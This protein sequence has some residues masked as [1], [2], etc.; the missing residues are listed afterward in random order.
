M[1]QFT[2]D[3]AEVIHDQI[4]DLTEEEIDQLLE[5]PPNIDMGDY[6]FPC[7]T[8]A[9]QFRK[10]PVAIAQELSEKIAVKGA[11]LRVANAGPYLNF[12]LDKGVLARQVMGEIWE[13][14]ERYG[15]AQIGDGKRI[16]IDYSSPNIAKPFGIAHLR[17]TVIGNALC[18]IY[19]FLG[20]KVIRVNH[21]GDWGT[22]FGK[23][24]VAYKKW[25]DEE[26]IKQNPIRQLYD[27]YVRF[28]VEAENDPS[29]EEEARL[30][31]KRL[32]D[33]DKEARQLWQWFR[34]LS[35]EEFQR[36]YTLLDIGFDSYDGES[37]YNEMINDTIERIKEK[38]LTTVSQDALIIPL[39]QYNLPPCLLKKRDDAT[40][41]A[42]RDIC[43]AEYHYRTYEFEKK[44]YVVAA[45]QKLHFQQ[46]FKV[47]ELME[48]PWANRCVHVEFGMMNFK[49]GKMSTRKGNIIV[50]EEVLSRAIE[51]SEEII[52]EKNPD[53]ADKKG[54][55]K[56]VGI[57]AVIFTDLSSKRV[58]D[59]TFDWDEVLNF[60]GETGPYLQY[61]HA[62]ISS[63]LRK[64]GRPV[65]R[66]ID[67]SLLTTR[68][69][70]LLVKTLERFPQVVLRGTENYEP[71]MISNYLLELAGIFNKFYNG[72]RILSE[73][74]ML[75]KARIF[76]SDSVRQTLYN[77]LTLLGIKAP[78]EM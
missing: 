62:R 10:N 60:D 44:L 43:A 8:L 67:C 5:I 7:F 64:Y 6:A 12:F 1:N 24:I 54:V 55:A 47:L 57:G 25:G 19:E 41:Y 61:T 58:K 33:G 34:D 23:Q 48:Y 70:L 66:D 32:E 73:D 72:Y 71:S 69:E 59:V 39:D 65:E 31:F 45:H 49:G 17:T 22:Q 30:W 14:R 11:I 37:F 36:I 42:T 52:E 13:K 29:L 20:Y 38:G 78:E 3:I 50:L 16:V 51:L 68:E 56:D 15:S 4:P 53:L 75:T 74:E 18:K 40:L 2:Q 77:G 26:L 76:L 21:L 27:L 63:V 28:H 35:L 46:I 9:K